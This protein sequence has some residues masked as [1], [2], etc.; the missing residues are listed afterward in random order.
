[1]NIINQ[2][3]VNQ[4]IIKFFSQNFFDNAMPDA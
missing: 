4:D 3:D 1:M 2:K